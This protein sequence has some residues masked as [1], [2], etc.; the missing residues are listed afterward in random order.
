M[1]GFT[2]S[3]TVNMFILINLYDFSLFPAQFYYI[4]VYVRK[5]ESCVQFADLWIQFK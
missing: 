1:S 3:Y 4:I 2:L 5:V